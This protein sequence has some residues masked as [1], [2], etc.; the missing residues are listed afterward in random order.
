MTEGLDLKDDLCRYQIY[1]KIGYPDV[2][3]KRV[4][5]GVSKPEKFGLMIVKVLP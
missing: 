3:D 2:T 5:T 1:V 4:A